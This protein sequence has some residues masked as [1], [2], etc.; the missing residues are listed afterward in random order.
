[1]TSVIGRRRRWAWSK[2]A[3]KLA[4]G[5]KKV[6]PEPELVSRRWDGAG[7]PGSRLKARHVCTWSNLRAPVTDEAISAEQRAVTAGH[8]LQAVRRQGARHYCAARLLMALLC[9]G[10]VRDNCAAA[11]TSCTA[12]A[13]KAASVACQG[14]A[15]KNPSLLDIL[16]AV[17]SKK[18]GFPQ[19][20]ADDVRCTRLP[21]SCL[22]FYSRRHVCG[23][24]P[25]PK[26]CFARHA[27]VEDG[28]AANGTGDARLPSL[29]FSSAASVRT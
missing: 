28:A 2:T 5:W 25:A 8:S 16:A 27:A 22:P 9:C 11:A 19:F 4:A 12:R 20:A 29:W 10:A 13:Y 21:R 23:G 15:P 26:A 3:A 18:I 6:R 17:A 14:Y 24:T 1:M 7:L